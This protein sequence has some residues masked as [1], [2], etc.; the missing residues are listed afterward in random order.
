MIQM[1]NKLKKN[2]KGFTLVELIVVLVI[3]A[4][5]A[6]FTIPAMLGFVNDAKAK[7]LVSQTREVYMAYQA[8]ITDESNG[9][10]Y[11]NGDVTSA[12][13]KAN[14]STFTP[15]LAGTG[16]DNRI[17]KSAVSKL[18]GDIIIETTASDKTVTYST[19]TNIKYVVKIDGA[20]VTNVKLTDGN[21]TVTLTSATD[22]SGSGNTST[23]KGNTTGL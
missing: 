11:K 19:A 8:A 7:A 12:E 18:V 10:G 1:I 21:Y 6:A 13:F 5:L 20:K 22:G 2:Q 9:T 4:I 17:Q 16:M 23:E 14:G 3:L 15:G